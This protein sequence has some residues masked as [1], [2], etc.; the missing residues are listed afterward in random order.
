MTELKDMIADATISEN[1]KIL[2]LTALDGTVSEFVFNE[3]LDMDSIEIDNGIFIGE[4][5]NVNKNGIYVS[6]QGDVSIVKDGKIITKNYSDFNNIEMSSSSN[7]SV[8][9]GREVYSS[10][11][12][13]TV[14]IV[15][16]DAVEIGSYT[17]TA[18]Q[19]Y[20]SAT[21]VSLHTAS[22]VIN[23]FQD[24]DFQTIDSNFVGKRY[25]RNMKTSFYLGENKYLCLDRNDNIVSVDSLETVTRIIIENISA[26]SILGSLIAVAIED[27][28]SIYRITGDADRLISE[29][30]IAEFSIGYTPDK[31]AVSDD[32]FVTA[33]K[34]A[35]LSVHGLDGVAVATSI[36]GATPEAIA[37][38]RRCNFVYAVAGKAYMVSLYDNY[39]PITSFELI[40][41]KRCPLEYAV[42]I[43]YDRRPKIV[44][45]IGI[46][47]SIDASMSSRMEL[48]LID[49]DN[50]LVKHTF[51]NREPVDGIDSTTYCS[52]TLAGSGFSVVVSGRYAYVSS[53]DS[54][55]TLKAYNIDTMTRDSNRDILLDGLFAAPHI[56]SIAKNTNGTIS[57]LDSQY[58]VTVLDGF[59]G[60]NT[61]YQYGV[62]T[63]TS[64][65]SKI[66]SVDGKNVIASNTTAGDNSIYTVFATDGSKDKVSF[67]DT[68]VNMI[69]I[70]M[71]MRMFTLSD[72]GLLSEYKQAINIKV[73]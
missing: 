10:S 12:N 72:A 29:L 14:G 11:E 71:G 59:I 20:T 54:G 13:F 6:D 8:V 64:I 9:D 65:D 25:S 1:R 60:K 68:D 24:E 35:T 16:G 40:S 52:D 55:T 39:K 41:D 66:T 22:E 37:I 48:L 15:S 51:I 5:V 27:K 4:T 42:G 30:P 38:D 3:Q 2:A 34:G 45:N 56:L 43:I 70:T 17:G 63:N 19:L 26:F 57:I 49:S 46:E 21:S 53:I 32:L 18:V 50:K 23:L 33:L 44:T 67:I 7:V 73:L 69:P 36:L 61:M 31:I 62:A 47:N 58:R 28:V